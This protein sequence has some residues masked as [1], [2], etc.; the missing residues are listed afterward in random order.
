M[1]RFSWSFI[2]SKFKYDRSV[3]LGTYIVE[4]N[5]T[6]RACAAQF[7]ISKSTV[8][9]DVTNKLRNCD[10]DLYNQV[11]EV[12]EKNKAERHLRG[13]AATKEKYLGKAL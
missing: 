10:K 1:D 9:K 13:G 3:L 4:N 8:H 6:V 2:L 5:V 7:G 11:R 12:L